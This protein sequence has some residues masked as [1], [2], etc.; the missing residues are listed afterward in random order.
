[1]PTLFR[2]FFGS[3]SRDSRDL[4]LDGC[5]TAEWEGNSV[6]VVQRRREPALGYGTTGFWL[7]ANPASDN[8]IEQQVTPPSAL[9]SSSAATG[10]TSNP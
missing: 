4:A 1:M 2:A 8:T 7:L 6:A 3:C 5:D 9:A 10:S